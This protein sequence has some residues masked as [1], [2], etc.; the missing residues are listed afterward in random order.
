MR[1]SVATVHQE[2]FVRARPLEDQTLA[3]AYA[4]A[5]QPD[6]AEAILQWEEE[7][8]GPLGIFA[9]GVD[10]RTGAFLGNFPLLFS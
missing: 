6:R 8:A 5:G 9:E 10:T 4:K 2:S 1:R 7:T 3:N